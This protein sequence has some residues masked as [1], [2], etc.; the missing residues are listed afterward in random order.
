MRIAKVYLEDVKEIIRAKSI[1]DVRLW[2]KQ[3]RLAVEDEGFGEFVLDYQLEFACDSIYINK[4]IAEYRN[5]WFE[6]YD[7]VRQC[8][9][10]VPKSEIREITHTFPLIPSADVSLKKPETSLFS[11]TNK[12]VFTIMEAAE[13]VRCTDK[14]IRNCIERGDLEAY[15]LNNS[16]KRKTW[17]ITQQ[18][19]DKFLNANKNRVWANKKKVA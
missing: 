12:Q 14:H 18:A 16:Q 9:V 2:C 15:P 6:Y 19:L 5:E 13:Y 7:K 10:F 17:R 4:L 3:K 8:K 11:G 1:E